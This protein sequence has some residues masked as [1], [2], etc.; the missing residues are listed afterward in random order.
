MGPTWESE[1]YAV[2]LSAGR[3]TFGGGMLKQR[4]YGLAQRK[5]GWCYENRPPVAPSDAVVYLRAERA[6]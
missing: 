1:G 6:V 4:F 2:Y 5:F 3:V